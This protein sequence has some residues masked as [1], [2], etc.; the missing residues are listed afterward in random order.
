MDN[1]EKMKDRQEKVRSEPCKPTTSFCETATH[2]VRGGD[3][4]TRTAVIPVRLTPTEHTHLKEVATTSRTTLSEFIRRAALKRRLP[5]P[6]VPEVNRQTYAELAKIG[7]NLNQLVR[8]LH[9]KVEHALD[10]IVIQNL[11]TEVRVLAREVLGA[12]AT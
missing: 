4:E 5:P 11:A 9:A 1:K 8:Q 12:G 3:K 2:F 6:P 7:H 10:L